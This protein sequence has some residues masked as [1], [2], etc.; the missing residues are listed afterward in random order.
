MHAAGGARVVVLL[1]VGLFF[2]ASIVDLSDTHCWNIAGALLLLAMLLSKPAAAACSLHRCCRALPRQQAARASQRNAASGLCRARQA[3]RPA[4]AAPRCQALRPTAAAAASPAAEKPGDLEAD[5][6]VLG[7]GIIGLCT[8]LALLRAD[9]LLRVAVLDRKSPCSGATGAGQGE[10]LTGDVMVAGSW[11]TVCLPP[12][13][14]RLH[15]WSN[16]HSSCL[17][18]PL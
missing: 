7:A 5:V 16:S 3:T 9:P 2:T 1:T 10:R 17:P 8:A 15:P 4:A 14:L 11:P 12:E 13:M 18:V 6:V